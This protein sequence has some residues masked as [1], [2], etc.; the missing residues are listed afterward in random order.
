MRSRVVQ[1]AATRALGHEPNVSIS[2]DTSSDVVTIS[3][4]S[5]SAR[6]AATDANSYA[7]AYV[8]LRRNSNIDDLAQAGEQLQAKITEIDRR[9]PGLPPGSPEAS[10]AGQQR[11]FLQ[12][13]LDQLQVSA[14]LNQVGGARVLSRADV[15]DTP[16]EPQPVRDVAIALVLGLLLGVGLAF[17]REY[18]DDTVSSRDDLERATDGL[19]V[20]GEISQV[21]A[22]RDRDAPHVVSREAPSSPAA[23]GYRTLRTAI[24]FL[25]VERSLKSIQIT[26]PGADDGK[27]TTLANLAVAFARLGIKVTVVCCDLRQPRL[28]E[29]FGLANN[30]GFTSVLLGQASTAEALQKVAGEPD[31]AVLSAG[32]PPP[33]PSEL[34]ASARARQV[35]GAL[36]EASDLVLVDSPPILPVT[37]GILISGMTEGTLLV[38]ERKVLLAAGDAPHS[39]GTAPGRRRHHRHRAQPHGCG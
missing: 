6:R 4:R 26:S 29:F 32:P 2:S 37:D 22:W 7:E 17:L 1:D 18:F 36:E 20:L 13:Q 12:Q 5:T 24:Q 31:I 8:A 14:N 28:H 11:A 16:V 34:L 19:P 33:N 27:T 23:E 38:A 21:S 35:I 15:P 30:V 9:L 25:G 39:A 10:T 3:A